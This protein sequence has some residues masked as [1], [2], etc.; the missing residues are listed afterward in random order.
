M[1]F[2]PGHSFG[3]V[4]MGNCNTAFGVS[5]MLQTEMIEEFLNIAQEERFDGSQGRLKRRTAQEARNK[6]KLKRN[7]DRR[8]QARNTLTVP[9]SN[10]CGTHYNAGYREIT[11]QLQDGD[12]YINAADRSEPFIMTLEHV[13]NNREFRGYIN[14]DDGSGEDEILIE[15]RLGAKNNVTAVGLNWEPA[16][17]SKYL[18]WHDKIS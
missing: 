12:L 13:R 5:Q 1:F 3:A 15:F 6:K 9:V 8:L 18:F 11:I 7:E 4:M 2:L 16:L 14:A 17:G 10:Y